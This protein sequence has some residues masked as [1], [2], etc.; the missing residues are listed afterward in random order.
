[1]PCEVSGAAAYGGRARKGTARRRASL[2]P[3][4]LLRPRGLSSPH[5]GRAIASEA[6]STSADISLPLSSRSS[7]SGTDRSQGPGGAASRTWRLTVAAP[8]APPSDGR[9]L[10]GVWGSTGL[11]ACVGP[12]A[13]GSGTHDGQAAMA[14]AAAAAAR[15]AGCRGLRPSR[16]K[17]AVAAACVCMGWVRCAQGRVYHYRRWRGGG[18]VPGGRGGQSAAP[19]NHVEAGAK[20]SAV[21]SRG[22][23]RASAVEQQRKWRAAAAAMAAAGAWGWGRGRG[24]G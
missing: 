12:P 13:A 17:Q 4:G 3:L 7:S 15:G 23:G 21:G 11:A 2:A 8:L 5:V 1:M 20:Q 24:L 9:P 10:G 14:G 16:R 6:N 22:A 18:T 19:L